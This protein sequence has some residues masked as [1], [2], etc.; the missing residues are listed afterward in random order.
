MLLTQALIIA[1]LIGM[2]IYYRRYRLIMLVGRG[3]R[4][5]RRLVGL[6]GVLML[7]LAWSL[8]SGLV[9][10]PGDANHA[11]GGSLVT[12]LAM[13]ILG[14]LGIALLVAAVRASFDQVVA[15]LDFLTLYRRNDR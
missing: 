8:I 9:G 10:E 12:W 14:L 3:Q 1:T 6:A 13:P 11:T 15:L 5:P 7:A 2:G 4:L